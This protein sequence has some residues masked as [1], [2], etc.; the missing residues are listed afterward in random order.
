MATRAGTDVGDGHVAAHAARHLADLAAGRHPHIVGC[1]RRR[2]SEWQLLAAHARQ[3][4]VDHDAHRSSLLEV[5]QPDA[6]AS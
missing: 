1:T 6:A 3:V 4:H 2:P 5:P